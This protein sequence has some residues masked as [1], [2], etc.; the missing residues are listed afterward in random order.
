[1]RAEVQTLGSSRQ[2]RDEPDRSREER[3]FDRRHV[4][5]RVELLVELSIV[6]Y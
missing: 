2:I 5:E 6:P 4:L 1:V 3:S